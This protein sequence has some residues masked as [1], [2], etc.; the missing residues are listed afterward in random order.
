MLNH[1]PAVFKHL[2]FDITVGHR[3][4]PIYRVTTLPFEHP[5]IGDEFQAYF[6]PFDFESFVFFNLDFLEDCS[7]VFVSKDI[8]AHI[9]PQEVVIILVVF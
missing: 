1:L 7:H 6:C 5:D 8:L 4:N 2:K 3:E 9:N